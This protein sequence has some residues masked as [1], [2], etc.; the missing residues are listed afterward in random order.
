MYVLSY[1][2]IVRLGERNLIPEPLIR[3]LSVVYEPVT[4]WRTAGSPVNAP[5]KWYLRL[6]SD[7]LFEG[8]PEAEQAWGN[9]G[10]S[11]LPSAIMARTCCRAP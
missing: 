3:P 1:G 2:P 6:W 7:V 11:A 5:I 9:P 10:Y 8:D 4:Q